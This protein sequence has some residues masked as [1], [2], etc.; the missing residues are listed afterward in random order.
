MKKLILFNI[1][2]FLT[3]SFLASCNLDED[4]NEVNFSEL[5]V[6]K[7]KTLM[8]NSH[9]I[10]RHLKEQVMAQAARGI[11]TVPD[12]G[13]P[14]CSAEK[15]EKASNSDY[16]AFGAI[17]IS[18]FNIDT[19]LFRDNKMLIGNVESTGYIYKEVYYYLSSVLKNETVTFSELSQ[20]V[21]IIP[22]ISNIY[23][24]IENENYNGVVI[25]TSERDDL[26]GFIEFYR[27][28]VNHDLDKE[29]IDAIKS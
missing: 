22:T 26:L 23:Q 14:D 2:L 1:V 17:L 12:D 4:T 18:Q 5:K 29:I 24:R 13:Q 25:N 16:N 10:K 28:K 9:A 11:D 6:S 21:N 7:L 20:F 8:N 15:I 27:L 19:R 3:F